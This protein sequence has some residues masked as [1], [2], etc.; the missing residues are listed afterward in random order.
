MVLGIRLSW[1]GVKR[2]GAAGDMLLNE[3]TKNVEAKPIHGFMDSLL[4]LSG[5]EFICQSATGDIP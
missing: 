3:E 4:K 5:P 1:L 2:Q